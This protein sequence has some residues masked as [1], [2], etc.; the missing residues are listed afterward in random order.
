MALQVGIQLYS[1]RD[2]TEKDFIG[3]LEAIAAMG[4]QGVE[5]A[6]YGGLEAEELKGHLDRLGLRAIASHTS[7]EQINNNLDESIRYN[8]AIGS[9]AI[10]CPMT[11]FS[12][13]EDWLAIVDQLQR[14]GEACRT[15]GIGF[16]YHNHAH[17]FVMFDGKYA[18][19]LL[20]ELA[21]PEHVQAE[22]DTCFVQMVGLDPIAYLL[23]YAGRCRLLHLKDWVP[24]KTNGTIE[25]G[26]GVLDIPGIVAA[27]RQ[28]DVQWLIVEQE[29]FERPSLTSAKMSLDYLRQHDL[30]L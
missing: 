13:K 1:V 15:A 6:G 18:L 21:S 30:L 26:Y 12:S 20:Y 19:D 24:G 5:F 7:L 3:T 17:E 27:A 23:K 9:Q 4:Y 10:I 28:S 16:G 2:E 11:T 22:I 29:E 8:L 25:V 14:A